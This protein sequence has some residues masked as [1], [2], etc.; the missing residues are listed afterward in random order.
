[1]VGRSPWVSQSLVLTA[2]AVTIMCETCENMLKM[3]CLNYFGFILARLAS[4]L[5]DSSTNSMTLADA[6]LAPRSLAEVLGRNGFRVSRHRSPAL[7]FRLNL[8]C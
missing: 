1:M 3:I 2:L 4:S 6:Q 8:H 5:R 7:S